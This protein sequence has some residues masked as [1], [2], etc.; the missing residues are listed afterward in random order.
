MPTAALGVLLIAGLWTP[1][2]GALAVL[3]AL[4]IGFSD[5]AGYRYWLLVAA[6]AAALTLLGPGAWSLDAKLFGWRRVEVD[7]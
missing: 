6:V 2:A 1:V 3:D 5:A 7:R 4:M